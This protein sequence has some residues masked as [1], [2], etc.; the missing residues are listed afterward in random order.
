VSAGVSGNEHVIGHDPQV[1]LID[2]HFRPD[3]GIGIDMIQYRRLGSDHGAGLPDA[4]YRLAKR[5]GGHLPVMVDVRHDG[6]LN[7]GIG[8]LP[9]KRQ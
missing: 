9:E 4:F 2:P 1:Y 6:K 3:G 7:A 8:H 5:I